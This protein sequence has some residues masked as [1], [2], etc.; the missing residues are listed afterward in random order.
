MRLKVPSIKQNPNYLKIKAEANALIEEITSIE[1]QQEELSIKR[2]AIA[3]FHA[4]LKAHETTKQKIVLPKPLHGMT[5][6][7][8]MALNVALPEKSRA[9]EEQDALARRRLGAAKQALLQYQKNNNAKAKAEIEHNKTEISK[10]QAEIAQHKADIEQHRANI[11]EHKSAIKVITGRV[12]NRVLD[13]KQSSAPSPK[14]KRGFF[15]RS[16]KP[17]SDGGDVA[18]RQTVAPVGFAKS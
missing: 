10:R 12:V 5:M 9:L 15:S 14:K 1:K 6:K 16:S 18:A 13:P 2:E 11:E 17:K 7:Q 4:S 3:S 8:I